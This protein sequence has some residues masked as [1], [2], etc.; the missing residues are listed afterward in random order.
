MTKRCL[1]SLLAA[2]F[3]LQSFAVSAKTG[4][5]LEID[6]PQLLSIVYTIEPA[7]LDSNQ[8]KMIVEDHLS[9]ANIEQGPRDDAQ[10]FLRVEKQAGEY[11]LYLDFSRKVRYHANGQCFT[12]DGFVWGRYV[13]EIADADDLIDDVDLLIEEF[14]ELYTEANKVS[15]SE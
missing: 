6:N 9:T 12:K 4:T 3:F 11:L 13:K 14:V 8:F 5:G 2:A 15:L 7:D 10:L 1:F